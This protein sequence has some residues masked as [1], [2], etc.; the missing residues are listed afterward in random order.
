MRTAISPAMA[1]L[2]RAGAGRSLGEAR[3]PPITKRDVERAPR[4]VERWSRETREYLAANDERERDATVGSVSESRTATEGS[5][6]TRDPETS[7]P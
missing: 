6:E 2:G 1:R 7:E 5:R 4:I 3:T